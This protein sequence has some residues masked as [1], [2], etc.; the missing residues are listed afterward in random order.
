[1]KMSI[2]TKDTV[3]GELEYKG[4]TYGVLHGFHIIQLIVEMTN[5]DLDSDAELGCI[6]S[7]APWATY[8]FSWVIEN[9]KLYLTKV[10]DKKFLPRHFGKDRILA[11]WINELELLEEHKKICHT[12][13]K[14]HSYLNRIKILKVQLKGG[15]VINMTKDTKSYNDIRLPNLGES[16]SYVTLRIESGTLLLYIDEPEYKRKEDQMLSLFCNYL[17]DIREGRGDNGIEEIQSVIKKGDVAVYASSKGSDL[18][19]MLPDLS[20]SMRDEVI[21]AKGCFIKISANKKYPK[22]KIEEIFDIFKKMI[23]LDKINP[24]DK[25]MS[26]PLNPFITNTTTSEDIDDGEVLI[27]VLMSI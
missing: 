8:K 27:S 14:R 13:E 21:E 17:E 12:Y 11:D 19:S 25:Y 23:G 2:P 9:D 20:F 15:Q 10:C 24:F 3:W 1:M 18:E 22:E 7:T 6:K 4:K 16:S 26:K 5:S